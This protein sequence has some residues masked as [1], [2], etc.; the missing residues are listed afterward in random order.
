MDG[1]K[2]DLVEVGYAFI[3]D[4]HKPSQ[5]RH[6]DTIWQNAFSSLPKARDAFGLYVEYTMLTISEG[7]A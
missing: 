2:Y 7:M 3:F 1:W 6:T 5:T 4:E